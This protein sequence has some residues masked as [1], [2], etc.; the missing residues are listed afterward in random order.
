[1]CFGRVEEG[2]MY[3]SRVKPGMTVSGLVHSLRKKYTLSTV[4]PGLTRDPHMG[5]AHTITNDPT[6]ES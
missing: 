1:M 5:V 6:S 3:G 4:I 2:A